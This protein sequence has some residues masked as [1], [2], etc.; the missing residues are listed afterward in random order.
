MLKVFIFTMSYVS[1]IP[2]K[3]KNTISHNDDLSNSK[4]NSQGEDLSKYWSGNNCAVGGTYSVNEYGANICEYPGDSCPTVKYF[5]YS[6]GGGSVELCCNSN[7]DCNYA[8]VK[9]Y[10]HKD[11]KRCVDSFF[12]N[13]SSEK[14]GPIFESC[15]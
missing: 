2:C 14:G 9:N 5:S 6:G 7:S 15:L 12:F 3:P 10:C 4:P 11:Y 13:C 1:S 8:A